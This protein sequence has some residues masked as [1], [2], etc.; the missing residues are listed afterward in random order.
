MCKLQFRLVNNT[1]SHCDHQNVT[2]FA[3]GIF[4]ENMIPDITASNYN[5]IVSVIYVCSHLCFTLHIATR[6][7][8]IKD[9]Y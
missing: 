1:W 4:L 7:P 9:I 2:V 3:Q 6:V 8:C 5:I